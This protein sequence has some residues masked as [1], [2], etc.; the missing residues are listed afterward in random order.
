MI[1]VDHGPDQTERAG[2]EENTAQHTWYF[3]EATATTYYR[4][5]VEGKRHEDAE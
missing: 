5:L 4:L 3:D 1:V 2:L